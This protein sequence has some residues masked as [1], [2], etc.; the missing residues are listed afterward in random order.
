MNNPTRPNQQCRRP[1]CGYLTEHPSGYCAKHAEHR[2]SALTEG[3]EFA[4]QRVE[5][6]LQRMRESGDTF[7]AGQIH[8]DLALACEAQSTGGPEP[9]DDPAGGLGYGG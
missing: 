4:L 3:A 6:N 1:G 5:R 2:K 8:R 9:I 7:Y